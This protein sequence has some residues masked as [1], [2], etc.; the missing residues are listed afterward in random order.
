M[1][2]GGKTY[3]YIGSS[4]PIWFIVPDNAVSIHQFISSHQKGYLSDIASPE[5]IRAELNKILHDQSANQLS[6]Q[7]LTENESLMYNRTV[8]YEK[9]RKILA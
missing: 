5:S 8:I 6:R 7:I 4:V 1:V 9:F 2:M 3:D